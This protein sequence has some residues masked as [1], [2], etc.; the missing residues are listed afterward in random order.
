MPD[1]ERI[2]REEDA[3]VFAKTREPFPIVRTIDPRTGISR[4]RRAKL[5]ELA[6][7]CP[8]KRAKWNQKLKAGG[9]SATEDR[10]TR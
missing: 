8:I 2:D 4:T 10:F 3:S 6:N 1:S 9:I 7:G 5:I